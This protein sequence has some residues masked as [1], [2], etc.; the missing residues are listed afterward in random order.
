MTG[1]FRRG[2]VKLLLLLLILLGIGI[3]LYLRADRPSLNFDFFKSPPPGYYRVTE[4]ID[5]DT[6][7]VSMNGQSEIIRMIGVDTPETH[8]P[9]TPVQCYAVEA[10][11]YTKDIIG[12]RSVRLEADPINTNRDRYDR[13]LRYVYLPDGSLLAAKLIDGGYG[14]A[15]TNFP[16]QKTEEFK[17]LENSAKSA[18]RG[19]WSACQITTLENGIRQT[20]PVVDF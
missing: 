8:R 3:F 1:F 13:L 15:Y 4:F 9:E 16:F 6:I 2:D 18:G 14:F 12:T 17:S 7:A 5:G 19:L 10:S 11:S 20:N